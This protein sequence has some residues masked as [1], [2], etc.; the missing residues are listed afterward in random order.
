M[1]PQIRSRAAQL[2]VIGL[3]YE[4]SSSGP[5]KGGQRVVFRIDLGHWVLETGFRTE[6]LL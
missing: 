1:G 2:H 3:G 4:L 5:K 6:I